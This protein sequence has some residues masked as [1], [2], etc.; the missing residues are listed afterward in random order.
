[1]ADLSFF[2]AS[3]V[4]PLQPM[5]VLPRGRYTAMI[6]ASEEKQTKS[7]T[8]AY[9]QLEFTVLD[10]PHA[11]RKVWARLNLDNPNQTAV[12]IARRE[13]AAIYQA[14]GIKAAKDS[15]ELHDKPLQIEVAVEVKDGNENNRIKAYM[16]AGNAAPKP[17]T[18][19]PAA[20]PAAK[21]A[22]PW[23]RAA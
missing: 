4:E 5:T 6:T 20:A 7:G 1:M 2:N 10:G 21:P 14:L 12:E 16:A 8:G 22:R 3:E 18:P 11:N 9:L 13:L 19:A 15:A 17:A 23:S